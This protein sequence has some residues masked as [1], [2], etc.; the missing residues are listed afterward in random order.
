MNVPGFTAEASLH[1]EYGQ[2]RGSSQR[3][4]SR[5]RQLRPQV[6]GG[7][8]RG[9]RAGG[10]LGTIDDYYTCKQACETARSQCLDTCEGTL[11]NPKPS[12]N[13]VI[14]DNNY[15]ACLQGCS[16]DIA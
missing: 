13:C 1:A 16:R 14:C 9:P 11:D 3:A 10:G 8:F 4:T 5:R 15:S 6:R 7:I 12:L 2:Y